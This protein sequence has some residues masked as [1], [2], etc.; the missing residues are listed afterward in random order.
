[1]KSNYFIWFL[2]FLSTCFGNKTAAQNIRYDTIFI[3]TGSTVELVFPSSSNGELSNPVDRAYGVN[4]SGKTALILKALKSGAADQMLRVKEGR[5]EHLFVLSYKEGTPSQ[6][7]DWSTKKKLEAYVAKKKAQVAK[8]LVEADN[9]FKRELWKEAAAMYQQLVNV[10]DAKEAGR[11]NANL[12]ECRKKIQE[13]TDSDYAVAMKEGKNYHAEEKY[14]EAK[15]AYLN[16]L[17]YKPGD[18]LALKNIA[19]NDSVWFVSCVKGGDKAN[20]EGKYVLAKTKYQEALELKPADAAVLKKFDQVKKKAAPLIYDIE[21]RKGDSA[22]QVDDPTGARSAY[23]SA[24]TVNPNDRYV[25]GQLKKVDNL[26][27]YFRILDGAKSLAAAA[28]NVQEC[29]KAISEFKRAS[30]LLPTRNFPAEK[31]KELTVKK[32]SFNKRLTKE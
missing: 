22:F 6:R 2:L 12:N 30:K 31:I 25:K 19:F 8:A 14:A 11:V 16:A 5:R 10:V 3:S 1:M 18:A 4:G 29:D 9:L 28:A 24:L 32:D 21:K 7:F 23:N 26:V 15:K 13:K 17:T 20:T 27:E